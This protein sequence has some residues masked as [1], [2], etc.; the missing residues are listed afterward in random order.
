MINVL[1]ELKE[2]QNFT[3]MN[4]EEK[5]KYVKELMPDIEN[6]E[7]Y[8]AMFGAVEARIDMLII[9]IEAYE[10]YEKLAQHYNQEGNENGE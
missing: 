4:Y 7:V 2:I 8:P 5:E 6:P 1:K 10:H 9:M 3:K